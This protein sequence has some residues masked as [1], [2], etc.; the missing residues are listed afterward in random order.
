MTTSASALPLAPWLGGK[1]CLARRLIAR[2][3]RIPHRCYAEPF[4]GMGGVFLRKPRARAEVVNDRNEDVV[5]LFRMT[6]EH[7]DEL[8]RQ[9]DLAV[10]SRAAFDRLVR[11]QPDE[12]TDI[13]RAARFAYLQA[14]AFGGKIAHT[15]GDFGAS[16]QP[17]FSAARMRRLIARAHRRLDGVTI[18]CLDWTDFLRRYDRPDTLF[19]LDPPY[20]GHEADYGRGL[21]SRADFARLAERLDGLKG[22]F[23]LSLGDR[24]EIRELFAWAAIER[25]ETSHAVNAARRVA[26]LLISK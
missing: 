3:A 16:R 11:G 15:P 4:V 12:L 18:E 23:L 20:W 1:R 21:F 8:G 25:V 22:R 26:E 19:Y 5:N 6:R 24:P 2:I 9:F 13:Q 14:L 17:R 7:P 10:A